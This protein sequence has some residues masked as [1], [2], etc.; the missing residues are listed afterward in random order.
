MPVG[1]EIERTVSVAKRRKT[2]VDQLQAAVSK[3]GE[4]HYRIA[5]RAGITPDM[6]DRFMDGRD[7]RISTA[8][9]IA[10]ALGLELRPKETK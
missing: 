1:W 5:K 9:K 4:T 10:E 6:V 7:I 2:I 3:S 8:A